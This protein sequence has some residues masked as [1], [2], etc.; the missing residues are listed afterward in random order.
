VRIVA[1]TLG[2]RL[3]LLDAGNGM[4]RVFDTEDKTLGP[5]W[6]AERFGGGEWLPYLGP[7]NLQ[8]RLRDV[9]VS[10]SPFTTPLLRE[11]G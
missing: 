10:G 6:T 1:E 3:L 9:T 5:P 2:G 7:Q 4:R 11:I 8:V